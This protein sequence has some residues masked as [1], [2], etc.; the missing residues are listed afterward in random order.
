M[1]RGYYKNSRDPMLILKEI[2]YIVLKGPCVR[3]E[4]DSMAV[5][6]GFPYNYEGNTPECHVSVPGWLGF[7]Q[8][9]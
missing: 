9:T 3:C 5:V 7:L 4:G 8:N 6:K 1:R 2:L